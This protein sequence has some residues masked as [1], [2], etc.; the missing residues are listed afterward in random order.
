MH[1]GLIA[2]LS[3]TDTNLIFTYIVT[4]RYK[5]ENGLQEGLHLKRP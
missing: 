5:I 2:I 4:G 3:L 1:V